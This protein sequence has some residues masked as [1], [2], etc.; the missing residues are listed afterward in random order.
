MH[1]LFLTMNFAVGWCAMGSA[2]LKAVVILASQKTLPVSVAVI[3]VVTEDAGE[4]GLMSIACIIA[5][6]SQIIFDSFFVGKWAEMTHEK[7][8]VEALGPDANG[9]LLLQAVPVGDAQKPL[10]E[11]R[12]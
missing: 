6:I 1:A 2:E 9:Q 8:A 10:E 11:V 4:Q 3:S 12:V 5:H 7:G